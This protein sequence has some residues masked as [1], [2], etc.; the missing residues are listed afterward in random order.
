MAL[1]RFPTVMPQNVEAVL[2]AA[3]AIR[4]VRLATGDLLFRD[5]DAVQAGL[6][7]AKITFVAALTEAQKAPE[8]AQAFMASVNGPVTLA[9]YQQGAVTIETAAAAW[10]ARLA[11][12]LASLTSADLITL[13]TRPDS[14]TKH[15]E[16]SA[17]I[18]A[19]VADPLRQSAELGALLASFEA[20]GG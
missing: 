15:I 11:A 2:R 6:E 18:P 16:R 12:T 5:L 14:Q 20:V 19:V 7:Q 4:H 1:S 17:F 10:N 8:A 13:V 3:S 9:Q